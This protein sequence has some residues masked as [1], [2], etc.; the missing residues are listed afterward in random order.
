MLSR[1]SVLTLPRFY[2]MKKKSGMISPSPTLV[3]ESTR[4]STVSQGPSEGLGG[5]NSREGSV[6]QEGEV[7]G[8]ASNVKIAFNHH[9]KG[10]DF[11]R[12]DFI[13]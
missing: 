11:T 8:L 6:P 9:N 4:K 1:K 5:F 13:T 3:V 2:S 10:P 7:H 12:T